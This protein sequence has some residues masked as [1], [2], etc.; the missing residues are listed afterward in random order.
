M[1]R[2]YISEL[3]EPAEWVDKDAEFI[4]KS[5]QK[6]EGGW[7]KIFP[8]GPPRWLHKIRNYFNVEPKTLRLVDKNPT[9]HA[10]REVGSHGHLTG[11]KGSRTLSGHVYFDE[12]VETWYQMGPGGTI[13]HWGS[14]V[15]VDWIEAPIAH[16]IRTQKG[17]PIFKLVCP[18]GTGGSKET[19]ISNPVV[20]TVYMPMPGGATRRSE[21]ASKIGQTN[22][23]VLVINRIDTSMKHQ[24]SYNF[25]ET[26]VLGLKTH[27]KYDVHPHH[28]DAV[29]IDPPD[30]FEPLADR[31]FFDYVLKRAGADIKKK[32]PPKPMSIKEQVLRDTEI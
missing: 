1:E 4:L 16:V 11:L 12:D 28:K 31:F 24:G 27:E 32:P 25:A 23:Q 17:V 21:R 8:D 18:D 10:M 15:K 9:A 3:R 22:Q 20:R 2:L 19:I 7:A 30:R 29:Y 5:V 14:D 26:A 13:Y 6:I